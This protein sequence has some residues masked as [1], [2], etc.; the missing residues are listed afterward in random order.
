METNLAA[1][2]NALKNA[3]ERRKYPLVARTDILLKAKLKNNR[4]ISPPS[5]YVYV[6]RHRQ[7]LYV[8]TIT[9]FELARRIF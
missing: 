5:A 6:T 4:A 1:A 2:K 3:S 8:L 7:E 9:A